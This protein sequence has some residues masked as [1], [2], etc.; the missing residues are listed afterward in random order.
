MQGG[1]R[2]AT[3]GLPVNLTLTGQ[4]PIGSPPCRI[5][6]SC[7]CNLPVTLETYTA[8]CARP[9]GR[10]GSLLPEHR[11]HSHPPSKTETETKPVPFCLRERFIVACVVLLLAACGR[12]GEGKP[13]Q[14]AAKVNGDEITIHQVN[15]ALQRLGNVPEA[16]AK[17]A[18]KQVLDRLVDQ[19]LLVQQ[20]V[21]K[22]LD[23]DPRVVAAMEA[24][25]RQILAQAYVE[26]V[27]G[28]AQKASEDQ[29]KEFYAQ[30][31]EL[32]RERRIYRFAQMVIA[33]PADKQPAVR[34]KL[35]ELD[36]LADKQKI[37][38]QLAEW[39]KAHDLQ[40]RVTQGTQ[41]AEQLPLEELPK[42]Q[43]MKAGDLLFTPG[44]QGLVVSQLI[45]AQTQPLSEDQA[46]PI[47][48]QYL[49]NR[50][51]LKL[52]DE[53]MKRLRAAAKIE[54]VGE[55]A[56][57]QG[58]STGEAKPAE[59]PAPEKAATSSSESAIQKGLEGMKK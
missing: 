14:V 7:L 40:F 39:L 26:Q 5:L 53:E 19:Q 25:K 38:P 54:Y 42:Y 43:Q 49:R 28:V 51:R 3:A 55:F 24:A 18:Q 48:E 4:P 44:P 23:R 13:S 31:P 8:S 50:E 1:A 30:H 57:A 20:A 32:F 10:A 27:A 17:Q 6:K 29:I 46:K 16:Q 47:I 37:L 52:S 45:A 33:A 41:A 35:E 58:P 22:K 9:A 15:E 59:K 56:Q 21:A 34:T 2:G 12:G 36:K 11:D